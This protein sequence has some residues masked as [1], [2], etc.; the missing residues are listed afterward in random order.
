MKGAFLLKWQDLYSHWG[1]LCTKW[2]NDAKRIM[3]HREWK[4]I[5]PPKVIHLQ[6]KGSPAEINLNSQLYCPSLTCLSFLPNRQFQTDTCGELMAFILF[7]S[8]LQTDVLKVC[9]R[10]YSVCQCIHILKINW[11]CTETSGWKYIHYIIFIMCLLLKHTEMQLL[12]HGVLILCINLNYRAAL[13]NQ[14]SSWTNIY[15]RMST[16]NQ[17]HR[18]TLPIP[19]KYI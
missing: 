6:F 2:P 4:H 9:I 12:Q 7:S 10:S 15:S 5:E 19:D 1:V 3:H 18:I 11:Y 13:V 14:L 8:Q 16:F 17:V